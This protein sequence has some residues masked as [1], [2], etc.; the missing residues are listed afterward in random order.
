MTDQ[1][2]QV[3]RKEE[4][5]KTSKSQPITQPKKQSQRPN[6][7]STVVRAEDISENTGV[8]QVQQESQNMQSKRPMSRISSRTRAQLAARKKSEQWK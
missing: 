5:S 6:I 7:L 3:E 4:Y 2:E 1:R 8:S